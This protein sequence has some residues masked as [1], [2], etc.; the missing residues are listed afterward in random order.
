MSK[1]SRPYGREHVYAHYDLTHAELPN[2]SFSDF[3]EL[4]LTSATVKEFGG[5]RRSRVPIRNFA[6]YSG[7]SKSFVSPSIKAL[8]CGVPSLPTAATMPKLRTFMSRSIGRPSP[9]GR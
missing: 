1:P 4:T 2:Q 3:S 5:A 7:S 9:S 8:I 6:Q